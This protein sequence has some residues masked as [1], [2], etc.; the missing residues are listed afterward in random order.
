MNSDKIVYLTLGIPLLM[1]AA[2]GI[3]YMFSQG[4]YGMALVFVSYALANV[5]FI[6]D[7]HK[8]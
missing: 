5:G 2:Q 8:I 4:R 6:L 3:H 7:S 1:Y